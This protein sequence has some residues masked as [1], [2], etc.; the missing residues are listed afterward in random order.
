MILFHLLSG[1][2]V[3]LLLSAILATSGIMTAQEETSTINFEYFSIGTVWKETENGTE[4]FR[5]IINDLVY[6]EYP[7]VFSLG[8]EGNCPLAMFNSDNNTPTSD[9]S[10]KTFQDSNLKGSFSEVEQYIESGGVN[11]VLTEVLG[12]DPADG[13]QLTM[14]ASDDPIMYYYLMDGNESIATIVI[15]INIGQIAVRSEIYTADVD[16]TRDYGTIYIYPLDKDADFSSIEALTTFAFS[17][18]P[19]I[20]CDE[21]D[22]L[23]VFETDYHQYLYCDGETEDSKT[24]L[25]YPV[26]P[27]EMNKWVV[28]FMVAKESQIADN[29]YNRREEIIQSFQVLK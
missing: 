2:I 16:L 12:I 18:N 13:Y 22:R 20:M 23:T 28:I 19:P 14:F 27:D 10:F 26:T 1:K 3:T 7:D 4:L 24:A 6:L 11:S 25:F 5:S 9:N 17:F 15:W 29:C 21:Q 8:Q